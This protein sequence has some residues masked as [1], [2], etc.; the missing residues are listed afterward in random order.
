MPEGAF[1][2]FTVGLCDARRYFVGQA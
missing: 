1:T 2:S